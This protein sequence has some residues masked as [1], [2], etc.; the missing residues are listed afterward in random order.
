MITQDAVTEMVPLVIAGTKYSLPACEALRLADELRKAAI[1]L[2][3]L[4]GMT[5]A[6]RTDRA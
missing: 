3:V 1:S 6:S 4:P 2:A 5:P